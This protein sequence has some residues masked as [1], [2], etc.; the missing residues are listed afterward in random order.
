MCVV[1]D[2]SMRV[3]LLIPWLPPVFL[4]L[5]FGLGEAKEQTPMM[6]WT[7]AFSI[8]SEHQILKNSLLTV[9]PNMTKEWKVTF[10]V[11][12]TH[13]SWNGLKSI[14]HLTTGGKGVGSNAKVGDRIPAIWFHKTRGVLVSSAL[15]GWASFNRFFKPL[16][17]AGEWTRIE[18]SQIVV[19]SQYMFSITIRNE[20][21]F[22]KPN[23]KPVELSGVKVYAGSPWFPGQ[24]G[25][26]R[27][28]KIE[29]K[30]PISDCI[31]R[32]GESHLVRC[33]SP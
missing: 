10:E 32:A 17:P 9:L 12:P 30:T 33:I 22:S 28:L 18:V 25:S 6:E 11:N 27:N 4:F 13:Y 24:K 26:L 8:Q 5:L 21:V 31:V 16:P 20:Q 1:L 29:M 15:G 14:L 19:S 3:F 7:T 23:T 2:L